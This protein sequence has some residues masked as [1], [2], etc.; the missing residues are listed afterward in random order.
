MSFTPRDSRAFFSFKIRTEDDTD[1]MLDLERVSES[2]SVFMICCRSSS[3]SE[4]DPGS[5]SLGVF[6]SSVCVRS[7]FAQVSFLT[8]FLSSVSGAGTMLVESH[9]A[10]VRLVCADIVLTI[11]LPF[12]WGSVCTCVNVIALTG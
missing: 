11:L 7:I 1:C 5:S 8:T 9:S 12:F 2:S 6:I 10:V 4:K 3:S